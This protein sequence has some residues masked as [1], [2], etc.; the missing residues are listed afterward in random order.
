MKLKYNT[1]RKNLYLCLILIITISCKR[2]LDV[3]PHS[4][5]DEAYVF[6]SVTTATNALIGVYG[7]LAGEQAYGSRLS[8]MY[9]VDQDEC[10]GYSNTSAGGGDNGPKAIARYN[11]TAENAQLEKPYNQLY[12]GIEG[13][14]ICI[15]NIPKMEAYNSGSEADKKALRRLYGEVLTLRAQF[16]FELIRNWGDVSVQ[17]EP[18]IDQPDLFLPKTDRDLI[19]NRI[20]DDLKLAA[21]L[22]PWRKEAGVAVDERITKGGVKAIRAKIAL[23]CGG[24]SLR[25]N[26]NLMERRSDY[27]EYYKIA[28]DECRDIMESANHSLNPNFEAIFKNYL[29]A[30]LID[31]SGEILFEVALA[32]SLSATD[33]RLTDTG[34][35]VGVSTNGAFKILP[36]YYYAFNTLDTRKDVTVTD[37]SVNT[38]N[39]RFP[40]STSAI[41]VLFAGKFRRDWVSNP[42]IDLKTQTLFSGINWP[43]IRYSDV[44]LMFAETENEIN[45]GATVAAVTAFEQVR[46]RGFRGNEAQIGATPT[47]KDEFFNAI[48][49]E[50]WLEFGGEGIRKYDLIRW[51]LLGDKIAE[52]KINL[53]KM[54]NRQAPYQN[55]PQVRY[56]KNN[57]PTMIWFNSMYAPAPTTGIPTGYTRVNWTTS[58][59]QAFITNIADSYRPNHAELLP[60]P[61]A[62]INTN[63]NLKQDYGY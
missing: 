34:P 45:N 61:Q 27:L 35:Q 15:K 56:Y 26:S 58:I 60:L 40:Q 59:T 12:G 36:T 53:T 32:G 39:N 29:D 42:A 1:G 31:P 17:F 8:I 44:L 11:A 37:Y 52:T 47:G 63:T 13:A 22:V 49:N 54:M 6:S 18:S 62:A 3:K 48:V 38:S 50:R 25:R 10:V 23:F 5:F 57:S 16:Y 21:E 51:N 43:V 33:S 24:Y 9:T 46:K 28:R 4:S 20:L 7:H 2:F 41:V 19:Y 30:H 14:N 55:L